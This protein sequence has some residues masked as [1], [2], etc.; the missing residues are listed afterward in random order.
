MLPKRLLSIIA[1]LWLDE[2]AS[3]GV[4][5]GS[6]AGRDV[7]WYRCSPGGIPVLGYLVLPRKKEDWIASAHALAVRRAILVALRSLWYE[8]SLGIA[9]I[10]ICERP[11]QPVE[12]AHP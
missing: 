4:R 8:A 7:L 2:R 10:E 12:E 9:H 3:A 1:H 11:L 6:S 5:S